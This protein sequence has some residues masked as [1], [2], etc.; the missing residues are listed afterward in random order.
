MQGRQERK[1]W[2]PIRLPGC[3]GKRCTGAGIEAQG[4][5]LKKQISCWLRES[6]CFFPTGYCSKCKEEEDTVSTLSGGAGGRRSRGPWWNSPKQQRKKGCEE[7]WQGNMVQA[8]PVWLFAMPC[9][10][11]SAPE[12]PGRNSG[13]LPEMKWDTWC[14]AL[15]QHWALSVPQKMSVLVFP[16]WA[17][18][19]GHS[20]AGCG[21][22]QRL[23][24]RKGISE[25]W[26]RGN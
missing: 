19:S 9:L 3:R 23:V 5:G 21:Q 18:L 14:E 22:P 25:S 7:E 2:S 26:Q 13:A 24:S 1:T 17:E 12:W 11:S 15:A 8:R 6:S 20:P 10:V 4:S 16:F